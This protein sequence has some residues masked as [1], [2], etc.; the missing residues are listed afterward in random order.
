MNAVDLLREAVD[1]LERSDPPKG[2]RTARFLSK[3]RRFLKHADDPD[4]RLPMSGVRVGDLKA[5]P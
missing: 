2:G 5:S 4:R 1:L 3:A